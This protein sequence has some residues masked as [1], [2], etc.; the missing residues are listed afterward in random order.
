[1]S[2]G[3]IKHTTNKRYPYTTFTITQYW[4]GL[5]S[6]N[7]V[8]KPHRNQCALMG[9]ASYHPLMPYKTLLKISASILQGNIYS[10]YYYYN[11]S[12]SVTTTVTVWLT[13]RILVQHVPMFK[14]QK[15]H[16]TSHI[17]HHYSLEMAKESEV[18][19]YTHIHNTCKHID[20]H[21]YMYCT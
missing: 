5:I 1:M 2:T 3:G 15:N 8:T 12:F 4:T 20:L 11:K 13:C 16:I 6:P 10:T 18:V 19:G 21:T 17:A 7:I 14:D 9:A